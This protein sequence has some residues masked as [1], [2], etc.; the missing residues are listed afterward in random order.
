M[1]MIEYRTIETGQLFSAH[2]IFAKKYGPGDKIKRMYM[3]DQPS[4]FS[5]DFGKNIPFLGALTVVLLG[6]II[7][8]CSW[9]G[10]LE[11]TVR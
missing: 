4:K 10:S 3:P 2:A 5:L 9:P 11:Y 8:F 1:L 7:W 6:M